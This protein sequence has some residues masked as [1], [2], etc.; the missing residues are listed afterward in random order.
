MRAFPK[1]VILATKHEVSSTF[2]AVRSLWMTWGVCLCTGR[3]GPWIHPPEWIAS[4]LEGCWE[5]FQVDYLS[6]YQVSPSA[7]QGVGSW[8][9]NIHPGTVCWGDEGQ[10]LAGIPARIVHWCPSPLHCL[11]LGELHVSSSQHIPGN[12]GL[13]STKNNL[14]LTLMAA[15]GSSYYVV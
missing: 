9:G 13:L 1:S 7:A 11:D 8:E 2:F 4:T 15:M 6:C 12:H 5:L 14:S 3:K 10:T